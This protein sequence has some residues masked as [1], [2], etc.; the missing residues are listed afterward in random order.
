MAMVIAAH[1]GHF[2]AQTF[3]GT[4]WLL[5]LRREDG[6]TTLTV[7]GLS[8]IPVAEWLAWARTIWPEGQLTLPRSVE[9][10]WMGLG[11]VYH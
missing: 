9:N 8:A 5:Q 10:G 7:T 1:T 11:P 2:P 6:L 3:S 4:V